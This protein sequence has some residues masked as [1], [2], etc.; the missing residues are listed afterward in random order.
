M[1]K[2]CRRL[3][4]LKGFKYHNHC[5]IYL[6]LC[7]DCY[8]VPLKIRQTDGHLHMFTMTTQLTTNHVTLSRHLLWDVLSIEWQHVT[9]LQGTQTL[10]LPKSVTVP[11]ADK[12]RVRKIFNEPNKTLY[13]M[14]KQGSNWYYIPS[15]N[16]VIPAVTNNSDQASSAIQQ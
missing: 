9:I 15:T 11:L 4:F 5:D 14:V 13:M 16:I 2:N 8:Y 10:A 3:E 7:H 6:F 1:Y 12:I